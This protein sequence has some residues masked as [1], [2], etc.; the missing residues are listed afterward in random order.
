[1]ITNLGVRLEDLGEA[2]DRGV[3]WEGGHDANFAPEAFVSWVGSI[4][5]YK[6]QTARVKNSR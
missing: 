1:M 4:T 6:A 3:F 2:V 5:G